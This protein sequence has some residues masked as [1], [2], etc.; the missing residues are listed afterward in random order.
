MPEKF[1][2]AVSEYKSTAPD[3]ANEGFN[4]YMEVDVEFS[5]R[6]LERF[7]HLYSESYKLPSDRSEWYHKIRNGIK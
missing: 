2:Q 3:Y 5:I 7:A 4:G 6:D 1:Q